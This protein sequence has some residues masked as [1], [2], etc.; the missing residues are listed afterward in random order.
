MKDIYYYELKL[1]VTKGKK[2]F[3]EQTK[4][5][6]AVTSAEKHE[7]ILKGHTWDRMY[8]SYY[9]PR[10][11]GKVEI[12]IEEVLSKKRVGSKIHSKKA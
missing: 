3:T 11:D 2:R 6:Y 10:Y 7:D 9:G 4:F 8:R 5:D 12:K 1:R